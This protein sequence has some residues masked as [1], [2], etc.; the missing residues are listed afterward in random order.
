M[1]IAV[2]IVNTPESDTRSAYEAAWR[3]LNEKG[4]RD[5]AG[6]QSHTAWIVGDVLHVLDVW[7]SQEHMDAWMQV[8]GPIIEESGMEL[9]GPPEIGDVL[10]VITPL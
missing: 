4:A 7:D 9:A 5:P 3:Q 1:A 6:R 8:I 2:H 10:Q